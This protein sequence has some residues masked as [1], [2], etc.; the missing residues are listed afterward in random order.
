MFM[1]TDAKFYYTSEGPAKKKAD[2][3]KK[4]GFRNIKIKSEFVVTGKK[5]MI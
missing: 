1:E 3:L 5:K 4:M 2:Q